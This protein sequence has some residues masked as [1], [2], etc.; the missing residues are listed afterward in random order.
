MVIKMQNKLKIGLLGGD[1]RQRTVCS[2]MAERGA[3]CAV[4][5]IDSPS[6]GT[7]SE[8]SVKCVDWKGALSGASAI[9]L[10]LPLTRDGV[11]LNCEQSVEKREIYIPR[12]TEIIQNTDRS[13]VLLAGKVPGN[14]MRMANEHNVRLI[15]YYEF[16]DFQIKN[17][18]PTAEGAIAIAIEE[19]DITL[20]DADC[21]VIGYGRIGR[22]LAQRLRALGSSVTCIA[23]SRRDLAFA[24]CD[25]CH[26]MRL[27][28]YRTSP[29]RFDIIFNTVPHIIFDD[30]VLSRMDK[31]EKI[32][33][34]ASLGGG[35]DLNCAEKYGIRALKALS[36]P[37]KVSPVTAGR[38]IFDTVCDILTEEGIL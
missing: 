11:R 20:A 27:D 15:D 28:S 24:Q 34:L 9:V 12:I 10:P 17:A 6:S 23:R 36:I 29:P 18:V 33:D 25:G 1:L 7:V 32:I 22:A 16:E 37:G 2:L 38:I 13:S 30:N 5:G 14:V 8:N 35:V 21:A 3:E 19:L 31:S 4:W 26:R